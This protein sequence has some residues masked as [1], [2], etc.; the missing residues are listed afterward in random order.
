MNVIEFQDEFSKQPHPLVKTLLVEDLFV[1]ANFV[2]FDGFVPYIRKFRVQAGTITFDLHTDL[3]VV[4]VSFTP[5]AES[6]TI[7]VTGKKHHGTIQTGPGALSL[8]S[9][10][11]DRTVSG[12]FEFHPSCVVTI[13]TSTGVY[14]I[15]GYSG[16]VVYDVDM[17]QFYDID[18]QNV[19][20]SSIGAPLRSV[21]VSLSS[22]LP[23]CYGLSS[24]GRLIS[25]DLTTG[26]IEDVSGTGN[27]LIRAAA[28]TTAGQLYMTGDGL[29]YDSSQLP[30]F[31]I[32]DSG[33]PEFQA[34]AVK[35]ANTIYCFEA[36]AWEYDIDLNEFT[37]IGALNSCVMSAAPVYG[38]TDVWIVGCGPAAST[39]D[40][41]YRWTPSTNT[42]TF[43]GEITL[44]AISPRVCANVRGLIDIEDGLYGIMSDVDGTTDDG[45]DANHKYRLLRIDRNVG[46]VLE[47]FTA[48]YRDDIG[49]V[50]SLFPGYGCVIESTAFTPLRKINGV[51]PEANNINLE[52]SALI[53]FNKEGTGTL[54]LSLTVDEAE[55]KIRR[56]AKYE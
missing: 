23:V 22:P 50:L 20:L 10:G 42:L 13:N 1:G 56:T 3:E 14:S 27:P 54:G 11:Q 49:D 52:D 37:E 39:N 36:S 5:A 43:V 32:S 2:Q 28:M 34:I 29:V 12:T 53:R 16:D 51:L 17:N 19:Q 9:A 24:N 33:S 18:G 41:L 46:Q 21:S 15:Q 30:P 8:I 25:V 38:S 55:L 7:S 35:D 45:D 31:V 48:D 44:E 40:R 26:A 47:Q 6:E 4:S